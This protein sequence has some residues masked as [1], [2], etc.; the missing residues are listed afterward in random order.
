ML[1]DLR[2]TPA[3]ERMRHMYK[4]W[5]NLISTYLHRSDREVQPQKEN[6]RQRDFTTTSDLN[7]H[8][9]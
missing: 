5:G 4:F 1:L 9:R 7:H 6:E 8:R 2:S 3:V